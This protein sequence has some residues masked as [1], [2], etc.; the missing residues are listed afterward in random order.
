MKKN[1][2]PQA[3]PVVH[4]CSSCNS[5]FTVLSTFKPQKNNETV[6]EICS[7]CHP[8]YLG[9][10]TLGKITGKAEKLLHKFEAGKKVAQDKPK[11]TVTK[12]PKKTK[13]IQ[14]L[15]DLKV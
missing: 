8:F 1:L 11:K 7:G 13:L 5:S 4:N 6:V 15:S 9:K 10:S 2:H 3:F 12:T 14:N